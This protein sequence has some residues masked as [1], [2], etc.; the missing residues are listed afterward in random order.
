MVDG[1]SKNVGHTWKEWTLEGHFQTFGH[2]P[3][4]AHLD[5]TFQ[6]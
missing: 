2:A 1:C 6:H 3:F 4:S 5:V